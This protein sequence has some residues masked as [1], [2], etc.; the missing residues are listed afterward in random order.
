MTEFRYSAGHIESPPYTEH[1]ANQ[2][3]ITRARQAA[4]ALFTPKRQP[5]DPSVS[6]PVPSAEQPARK[7][8]VLAVLL[9]APVRDEEV[10]PPVVFVSFRSHISV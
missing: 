3:Q 8:R 2:G 10:A 7:L 9:P 4:E 6:D 5:V 1:Q